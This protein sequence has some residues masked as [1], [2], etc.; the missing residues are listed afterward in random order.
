MLPHGREEQSELMPAVSVSLV[1]V[2]LLFLLCVG[3]C[4]PP[5]RR[6]RLTTSGRGS[7]GRPESSRER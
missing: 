3:L 4:W 5:I 2:Y 1:L 6:C 7:V